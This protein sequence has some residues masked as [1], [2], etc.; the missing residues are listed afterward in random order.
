MSEVDRL[1]TAVARFPEM[2]ALP[3]SVIQ[4][5]VDQSE[6][7]RFETNQT[8]FEEG[9]DDPRLMILLSGQV[10]TMRRNTD[11]TNTSIRYLKTGQFLGLTSFVTG[12]SRSASAVARSSVAVRSIPFVE[13]RSYL[14]NP[15]RDSDSL[16]QAL[17]SHMGQKIRSKNQIIVDQRPPQVSQK[18]RVAFFDSQP[19]MKKP[20]IT[21]G[22]EQF[23]FTFVEARLSAKTAPV[24]SGHEVVC[25]FVNDTIDDDAAKIL[26]DCGV[27]LI[28]LRC[29]GFNHVDLK[30]CQRYGLDV[31]RVPAYSPYAVA[32]HGTAMLLCLNRRLHRAYN[33]VREGNFKLDELVGFDLH[34]KTVGVIGTG[35]IGRIFVQQMLGFGARVLAFDKYPDPELEALDNVQ[36]LSLAELLRSSDIISLHAPLTPETKH[37]IDGD[38]IR[39]MKEGVYIVNTSRGGLIDTVALIQGLKSKKIGGAALDVYEEEAEYFFQDKSTEGISD[40]VLARLLTFNNVLITSHQAFMT[41]EALDKITEVTLANIKEYESGKR[42]PELSNTVYS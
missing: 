4:F 22:G 36:Y 10:E 21:A 40:D 19:Y 34:G 31:V 38:A 37:L 42:G 41:E 28:A 3:D 18:T 6:E 25:S 24:A 23:E 33:R 14:Y 12:A 15:R 7:L 29:A 8:I 32:E 13:L 17:L 5:I 16:L 35:K 2:S 1:K 26:Q 11:G 39:T 27:G 9:Q 30:A 20:F